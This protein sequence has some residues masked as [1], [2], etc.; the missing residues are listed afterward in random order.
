ML[1]LGKSVRH[2]GVLGETE[3]GMRWVRQ[4]YFSPSISPLLGNSMLRRPSLKG[5]YKMREMHLKRMLAQKDFKVDK[6]WI[7][8]GGGKK[9][10]GH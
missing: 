9:E 8:T 10:R 1:E 6:V 2:R 4:P 7:N 5:A 3:E